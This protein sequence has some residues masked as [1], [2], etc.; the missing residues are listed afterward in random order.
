MNATAQFGHPRGRAGRLV[1][2]VMALENRRANRLVVDLLDPGPADFVLEL[3]CGPGVALA[4]V[5]QRARFTVGADASEAMVAQARRRL[6]RAIAS[7]RAEVCRAEAASLPYDDDFFTRA[8]ALHTIHHWECVT[9]GSRSCA[10][11]SRRAAASSWP[12]GSRG[13]AA[14]RTPGGS[15]KRLRPLSEEL[16][17]RS[18]FTGVARRIIG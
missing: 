15:A 11:S 14:T 6:R 2:A 12:T 4:E 13:R 1:G 9:A 8:F 7:D 10:A 17:G 16:L 18:G 5:A 3:G